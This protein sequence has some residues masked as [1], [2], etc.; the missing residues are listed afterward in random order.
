MGKFCVFDKNSGIWNLWLTPSAAIVV[1]ASCIVM[2]MVDA[3]T[4]VS[5]T[6]VVSDV[7]VGANVG[8]PNVVVSSAD[9]T[10][11]TKLGR[12]MSTLAGNVMV[13]CTSGPGVVCAGTVTVMDTIGSVSGA[14]VVIVSICEIGAVRGTVSVCV[15]TSE[16]MGSR[17][18]TGKGIDKSAV[19]DIDIGMVSTVD[20]SI[21]DSI[22]MVETTVVVGVTVVGIADEPSRSITSRG[23]VVVGINVVVAAEKVSVL[24]GVSVSTCVPFGILP[25]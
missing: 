1:V 8:A 10:C 18:G 7:S 15:V 11:V 21:T 23:V 5:G 9:D 4:C 3:A 16:G 6:F 19:V 22:A 12:D 13:L 24:I 20:V 17:V 25:F 2:S 14:V